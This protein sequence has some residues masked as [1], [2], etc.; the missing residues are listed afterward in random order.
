MA[1]KYSTIQQHQPLRVPQSFDKQAR[2]LIIQL[3]EIFDD[4]YKRFGR[5]KPSDFGSQL[6]ELVL[7]EGDD[8]K[9]VSV[10]QTVD[11]IETDIQEGLAG[12]ISKTSQYTTAESIVTA[13]E[14]YTNGQL[15]NYYTKIETATEVSTAIGNALGD[16]YTKTE[17]ASQISTS[18]TNALGDY[19]TKTE[20]ASQI[21]TS[22]SSAL[23]NYY[24]KTETASQISTSL[25]T[26]LGNYYTKTETASQISTSIGTA[27]GDYYTKTETATQISTS[28]GTALGDYYTKTETA[29]QITTSIGTAL[30]DYY[31][32]TETATQIS[33]A[34]GTALGDYST[35][36]QTATEISNMVSAVSQ[37]PIF[38]TST[39][40]AVGD[41]VVYNEKLYRFTAAHSAGDWNS[42]QVEEVG[43]NYE[44][45][46]TSQTSSMINA[47][48]SDCYGKVSGITINSSGVDIT[49][50][51]Y[52]KVAAGNT[53]YWKYDEKGL[54]EYDN[55]NAAKLQIGSYANATS[56]ILAGIYAAEAVTFNGWGAVTNG[57]V[58]RATNN[59]ATKEIGFGIGKTGNTTWISFAP[60]DDEEI[61][62]GSA[63]KK[64]DTIYGKF[65]SIS[66]SG[67]F[68]DGIS[69]SGSSTFGNSSA[70]N[71][72]FYSTATF[73]E[74]LYYTTLIQSSSREI[75]HDITP[76]QSFGDKIDQL[77]T[78]SF[79]Y[80]NDPNEKTRYG[81][82]Y[83]DTMEV[84]PEIC[85]TNEASKAINYIELIPMIVKE[86]QDLRS[87]V[88]T[89]EGGN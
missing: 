59:S 67:A 78:V 62:L 5:L 74:D 43:V 11:G 39:A 2:A 71:V 84:F 26:A 50:S 89:I 9:Y 21:S 13:A 40:Y 54:T 69:V 83:E 45:S 88:S 46:T 18:I 42:Q 72:H 61:N 64:W 20:T 56:G 58:F 49:G 55:N 77:Q 17:T 47:A 27:L 60:F 68:Y 85:T 16:Y 24:T 66:K 7:I 57:I 14:S 23:G 53:G 31:T 44:Y 25:T 4:I 73:D 29:S 87:R 33:S 38:S 81:L 52:V 75:K 19:Y 36:V 35:S 48:V 63:S 30:G 32:K 51:K 28:I 37:K 86:I 41:I 15:T 34:I 70:D 10:K 8:G 82:I 1:D 6:Q 22:I 65:L 80:D 12:K 76:M 3:D 79:V